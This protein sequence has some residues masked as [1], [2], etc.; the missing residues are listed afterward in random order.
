[1]DVSEV[2][3]SLGRSQIK[4]LLHR[5]QAH[6]LEDA[7][8]RPKEALFERKGHG[9]FKG[10]LKLERWVN[11]KRLAIRMKLAFVCK[12]QKVN[13]LRDSCSLKPQLLPFPGLGHLLFKFLSDNGR[14]RHKPGSLENFWD[15]REVGNGEGTIFPIILSEVKKLCGNKG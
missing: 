15:L 3:F 7:N 8:R 14:K 6:L 4:N 12:F 9:I 1:M 13:C 5:R 10:E 11:S 2:G